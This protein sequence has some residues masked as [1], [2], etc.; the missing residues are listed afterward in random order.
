MRNIVEEAEQ[1]M[2][3]MK[4]EHRTYCEIMGDKIQPFHSGFC[5][6]LAFSIIKSGY[7]RDN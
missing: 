7:R 1:L 5:A 4:E 2:D 6:K 3:L